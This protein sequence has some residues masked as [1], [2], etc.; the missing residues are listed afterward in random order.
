MQ[1][2]AGRRLKYFGLWWR[3]ILG[4]LTERVTEINQLCPIYA[5]ERILWVTSEEDRD[6]VS[7]VTPGL[8]LAHGS[9]VGWQCEGTCAWPQNRALNGLPCF[10]PQG[11]NCAGFFFYLFLAPQRVYICSSWLMAQL[12]S[13]SPNSE[14]PWCCHLECL[15]GEMINIGLLLMRLVGSQAVWVSP[16]LS[17]HHNTTHHLCANTQQNPKGDDNHNVGMNR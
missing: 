9:A 4:N 8:I 2:E 7:K 17:V 12:H 11:S 6:A 13:L 5:T 16:C 14:T 3:N 10:A 1:S 15:R